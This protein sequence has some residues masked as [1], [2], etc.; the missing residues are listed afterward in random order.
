M[1][2]KSNPIRRL[3]LKLLNF[4]PELLAKTQEEAN[5]QH[6][7]IGALVRDAVEKHLGDLKKA[8]E[9]AELKEYATLLLSAHFAEDRNECLTKEAIR[10]IG[11]NQ[12]RH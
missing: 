3:F 8:R 10:C 7:S 9:E 11:K 4:T 1:A 6:V 2:K 12:R 5:F